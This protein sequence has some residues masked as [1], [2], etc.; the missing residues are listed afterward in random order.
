MLDVILG[1]VHEKIK[2]ICSTKEKTKG[3]MADGYLVYESFYYANEYIK[4]IDN[5]P[6]TLVWD[7][8]HY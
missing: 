2:G 6:G 4:K 7:D 1:E 8:E 5:R 3:S